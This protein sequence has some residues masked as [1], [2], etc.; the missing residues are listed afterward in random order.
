LDLTGFVLFSSAS[1][2]V[3]N[4]GQANYAA[5]NAVLDALA[6]QRRAKG[7]AATSIAAGRADFA[8]FR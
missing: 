4:P 2:A 5:A 3:G 1:G 7:L 6:D 8:V